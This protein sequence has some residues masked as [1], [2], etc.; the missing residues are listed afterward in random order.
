MDYAIKTN[1]HDYIFVDMEEAVP[2]FSTIIFLKKASRC[3]INA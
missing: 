1:L 3:N 2:T